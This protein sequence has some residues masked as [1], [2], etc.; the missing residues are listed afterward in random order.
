[1]RLPE[2]GMFGNTHL[3]MVDDNNAEIAARII[4]WLTETFE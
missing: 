1:M 4:E 2:E 3:L